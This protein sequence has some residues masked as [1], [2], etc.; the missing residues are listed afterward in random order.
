[1]SKRTVIRVGDKVMIVNPRFIVRVGYPLT[2]KDLI[3]E[4]ENH[5]KLDEAASLLGILFTNRKSKIARDFIVGCSKAM[6]RV[7]GFGGKERQIFYQDGIPFHL[8]EHEVTEVF[9]KRVVKT[10]IYYPP[11]GGYDYFGEYDREP[12][13]LSNERTHI[14]L[15][16]V[17]GEIESTDVEKVDE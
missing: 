9:G 17:F 15:M 8:H 7:R 6:V 16:T 14:L 5:P 3:P 12:G 13:G 2:F 11:T 10:G 1:M 4:F